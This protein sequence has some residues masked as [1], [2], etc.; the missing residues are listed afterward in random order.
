MSCPG[1]STIPSNTFSHSTSSAST[2][3]LEHTPWI[4]ALH[5]GIDMAIILEHAFFLHQQGV[6]D[7]II[8]AGK[9]YESSETIHK[10]N[11]AI[12]D[13]IPQYN[14][15]DE[16]KMTELIMCMISQNLMSANVPK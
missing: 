10:V 3:S 8:V 4:N 1:P 9:L 6:E 7:S 5:L 12:F 16:E 14:F 15:E 13:L 11:K 2:S